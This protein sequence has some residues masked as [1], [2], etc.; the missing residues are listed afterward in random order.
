MNLTLV[1]I[2]IV[3]F[4]RFG[5]SM[6]TFNYHFNLVSSADWTTSVNCKT[7]WKLKKKRSIPTSCQSVRSGR[8]SMQIKGKYLPTS[9]GCRNST[10]WTYKRESN[11]RKW[12]YFDPRQT[13]SGFS[14]CLKAGH[15]QSL[16][17]IQIRLNPLS[18]NTGTSWN[19]KQSLRV[20][21]VCL[22][23]TLTPCVSTGR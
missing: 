22:Y 23:R 14:S 11:T 1:Q 6:S 21:Y 15:F 16:R 3:I 7:S 20:R 12:T 18:L 17:R 9:S 10:P 13:A 5:Q 2:F 4:I 8:C 19:M